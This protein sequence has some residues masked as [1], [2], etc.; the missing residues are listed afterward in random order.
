MNYTKLLITVMSIQISAMDRSHIFGTQLENTPNESGNTYYP[1]ASAPE[2]HSLEP[3]N[4]KYSVHLDIARLILDAYDAKLIDYNMPE[5]QE[6]TRK[7]INDPKRNYSDFMELLSV[8]YFATFDS[9]GK[10]ETYFGEILNTA[11][12]YDFFS[13]K[14]ALIRSC[15]TLSKTTAKGKASKDDYLRALRMF[16]QSSLSDSEC[17]KK[18]IRESISELEEIILTPNLSSISCKMKFSLKNTEKSI[19]AIKQ[20]TEYHYQYLSESFYKLIT[21]S[22]NIEDNLQ[23]ARK[24]KA[25]SIKAEEEAEVEAMRAEAEAEEKAEELFCAN[26]RAKEVAEFTARAEERKRKEVRSQELAREQKRVRAQELARTQEREREEVRARGLE[27]SAKAR[28]EEILE[29]AKSACQVIAV[30]CTVRVTYYMLQTAYLSFLFIIS[31]F[32]T[33]YLFIT[34]CF[35]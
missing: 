25:R 12:E 19:K 6:L 29:Y 15:T 30:M 13:N 4:E 1:P 35:L 21:N 8:F 27:I 10:E 5:N 7:F 20:T 32:Q 22:I 11:Q 16:L 3:S 28:Q 26:K 2:F 34:S 23:R 17:C 14:K 33:A 18:Y 31:P 9:N 24:V